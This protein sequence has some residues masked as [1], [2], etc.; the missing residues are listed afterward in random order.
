MPPLL[1]LETFLII[2]VFF[3]SA[4]D[5]ASIAMD[6]GVVP[7]V[8]V[9]GEAITNIIALGRLLDTPLQAIRLLESANTSALNN[10]TVRKVA[11]TAYPIKSV[12]EKIHVWHLISTTADVTFCRFSQTNL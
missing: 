7:L 8:A 5:A 10:Y 11:I 9:A 3:G 12:R 6:I 4:T 2:I 1:T